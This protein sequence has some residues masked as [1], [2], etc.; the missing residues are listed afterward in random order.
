VIEK[1][2]RC[3]SKNHKIPCHKYLDDVLCDKIC[4]KK[5]SCKVH[6]CE[7]KC[8]ISFSNSLD[9]MCMEFC[10]RMLE[11]GKHPCPKKCHTGKCGDCTIM[12]NQTLRCACGSRVIPAPIKCGTE[13]PICT[14]RCGKVLSCGHECYYACHYGDCKPCQEIV[15]KPCACGKKMIE[16]GVCS[17]KMFCQSRCKNLLPCGH[18][19]E[20]NCHSESCLE[21][22]ERK[23][24]TL[25]N[26]GKNVAEN[27]CT[28]SCGKKR[29]ACSHPCQALCHPDELECPL[30]PCNYLIKVKCNCG[31]R[32]K[33]VK[34]DC[35]DKKITK[36]L[37]CDDRCL[38]LQRFKALYE[39]AGNKV[40]Y[41]GTLV[42]FAN[43]NHPYLK[44]LEEKLKKLLLTDEESVAI[45]IDKNNPE[46][47]KALLV[48][49]PRHYM[50]DVVILKGPKNSILTISKTPDSIL[51][52]MPLSLYIEK[53]MSKEI[54]V[55]DGPF[56]AV[57]RFHDL[58]FY[59]NTSEVDKILAEV[60]GEYYA[61][62]DR[63]NK[64]KL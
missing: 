64:V 58:T 35:T 51:P 17:V 15:D 33:F 3:G 30:E 25:S 42:K 56:D 31:N 21:I 62:I 2:C 22:S 9:H 11:C 53:I 12:M 7:T 45:H 6:K 20:E 37:P 49:M 16:K 27:G 59:E 61:E 28:H 23:K 24:G 19:C 48:L 41:P 18:K 32:S 57:I 8:C 60:R 10:G 39:K 5:K 43:N 36:S 46:K 44:K 14:K 4:K 47:L 63:N 34:C 54:K 52:Q 26:E 38:N 55:D 50:L 13:K 40:Y 1:V 29:E